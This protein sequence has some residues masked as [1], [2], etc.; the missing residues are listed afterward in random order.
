MKIHKNDQVLIISGKDRGK[1][2]KVLDVF[3]QEGKIV[4]EGASIRKKNA[5]PKK[6]GEKGQVVHVPAAF[7]VANAVLICP[8]CGKPTRVGYKILDKKKY[9]I[10]KKCQS[11]F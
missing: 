7:S 3:A 5:K 1:K 9:R 10:C 2:G 8:K 6:S 11:E 4:V